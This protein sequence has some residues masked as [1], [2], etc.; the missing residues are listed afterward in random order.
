MMKRQFTFVTYYVTNE[1]WPG[2]Y[3]GFAGGEPGAYTTEICNEMRYKPELAS[4]E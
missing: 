2:R 1:P 4:S 3:A